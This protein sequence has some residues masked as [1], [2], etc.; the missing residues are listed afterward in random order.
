[1]QKHDLKKMIKGWL[2][3]NFEPSVFQTK[4]VEVAIKTYEAGSL[5]ERHY[6]K[7]ATEITA[8]VS[9]EVEMNG[10]RFQKND[11]IVLSPGEAADFRV[12][13]KTLTV[14][15]KIPGANNDKYIIKEPQC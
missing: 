8:I 5:E 9:G 12:I 10:Q 4:A 11:I 15:I 1:M 3:G 2:I 6:H 7:I 14:V 13:T